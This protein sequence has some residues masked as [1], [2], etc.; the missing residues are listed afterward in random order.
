MEIKVKAVVR[1]NAKGELL[2]F[3]NS[4]SFLGD[5]DM[6]DSRIIVKAHE[7]EG[8]ELNDKILLLP[9]SKGSTGGSVVLYALKKR[10]KAPAGIIV[11]KMADTNLVEGA[12]FSSVPVVCM[13]EEEIEAHFNTG[14]LICIDGS[15]GIVS[16][17]VDC[18]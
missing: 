14:D 11:K 7:H 12:I 1:G 6:D 4:L 9:E 13:P 17:N 15:K 10:N 8:I 5:V 3:K 18:D 16:S 2:I